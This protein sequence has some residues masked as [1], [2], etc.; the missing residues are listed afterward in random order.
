MFMLRHNK[1]ML[2]L[3]LTS[4]KQNQFISHILK[5]NE[6]TVM[7]SRFLLSLRN[8]NIFRLVPIVTCNSTLVNGPLLTL[9]L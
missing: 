2:C 3:F 4:K 1:D 8:V 5:M 6:M 7:L 9:N